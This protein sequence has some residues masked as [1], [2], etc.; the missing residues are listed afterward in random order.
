MAVAVQDRLSNSR[1]RSMVIPREHGAW[2]ILLVPLVTGAAVGIHSFSDALAVLLFTLVA[3]SLFWLRTPVES[4]IGAGPLRVQTDAEG[5]A[6]LSAMSVLGSIAA[7]SLTMLFLAGNRA[8]L[9]VLGGVAAVAF[10]AQA[11]LKKFGRRY[12][13]VAQIIGSLGLTATAPGAYYVATG[14]LDAVALALWFANWV[15]AG[16]QVHFVQT[17]IHSARLVTAADKLRRGA[18]FFFG[19][20][21][22][23]ALVIVACWLRLLPFVA[24]LA[25]VP[26]MVR[27]FLW[28]FPGEKPLAVKRLGWTELMHAISFGILLVV[29][30]L[31]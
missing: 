15:F 18:S 1:I 21:A 12:Y 27:G 16:N 23:S 11:I 30:F 2:G 26:V 28:F 22:M 6:V 9:L 7:V 17:R 29:A 4:C 3:L 25:F 8:G 13:M 5:K 24:L 31:L 20:I 10:L 19:Q 14:R